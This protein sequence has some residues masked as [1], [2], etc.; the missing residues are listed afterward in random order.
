[1]YLMLVLNIIIPVCLGGTEILLIFK[2]T[3][4]SYLSLK[5]ITHNFH[6]KIIVNLICLINDLIYCFLT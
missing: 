6:T 1:M 2:Y 5:N 3:Y 4:L